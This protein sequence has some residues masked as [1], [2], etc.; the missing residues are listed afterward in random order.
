M[1][2]IIHKK[3]KKKKKIENEGKVRNIVGISG[4]EHAT[5]YWYMKNHGCNEKVK[6]YC[7]HFS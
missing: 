3:K 4:G 5:R 7:Y 2:E 1:Y 6:G